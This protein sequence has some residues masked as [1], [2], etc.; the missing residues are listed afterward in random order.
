MKLLSTPIVFAASIGVFV[1]F[2]I[3]TVTRF[4]IPNT[5]ME[6]QGPHRKEGVEKLSL[7]ARSFILVGVDTRGNTRVL[8]AKAIEDELPIASITKLFTARA[9]RDLYS[10][11]Y[12]VEVSGEANRTHGDYEELVPGDIY[13]TQDLLRAMMIE[14]NNDAAETFASG[15]KEG[16]LVNHMNEIADDWGLRHTYFGNPTGLDTRIPNRSTAREVAEAMKRLL[17]SEEP[18]IPTMISMREAT[19]CRADGQGCFVATTTNALLLDSSFP[20]R[21]IAGKTGDTALAKK[22]LVLAAESPAPGWTLIS[23]VLGSDDHFA[24]TKKLF[25]W[26]ARSY[27]WK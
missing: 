25:E 7:S 24:D 19:I 17:L 10:L 16:V 5:Q 12:T 4:D 15:V 6:F 8:A 23:V 27:E 9:V 20:M 13:H 2:F 18:S 14:S 3:I 11:S 22:N 1:S 26:V 21:I